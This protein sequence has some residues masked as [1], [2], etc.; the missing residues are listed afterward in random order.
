MNRF[1]LLALLLCFAVV[2]YGQSSLGQLTV[3]KIM[4]DPKWIGTSPSTISWSPE[5]KTL[6]FN[7]NPE[8]YVSD[9][10]YSITLQNLTPRKVSHTERKNLPGQNIRYNKT[11]TKGTY[12][13]N[14]DIYLYDI[15]SKVIRQIT[16]TVEREVA[17]YFSGDDN[18]I[19]FS[20]RQ[21]AIAGTLK[22]DESHSSLIF[23]AEKRALLPL[24]IKSDGLRKTSLLILK[25]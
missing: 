9:S 8:N 5:S 7:W 15:N 11:Y 4:R 13:K 2:V 3:E 20:A 19:I 25:C 16:N 1:Y 10:L 14:G 22:A 6:F 24:L 17:P 23:E 21:N 12:E 18:K